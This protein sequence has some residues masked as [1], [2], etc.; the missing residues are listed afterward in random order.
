[1][2]NLDFKKPIFIEAVAIIITFLFTPWVSTPL[3]NYSLT[4]FG[5]I[6]FLADA[7]L[8]GSSILIVLF[9]ISIPIISIY[10]IY[11]AYNT[12]NAH[13]Y[14][15]ILFASVILIAIP[16]LA[17]SLLKSGAGSYDL[18]IFESIFRLQPGF[19]YTITAAGILFATSLAGL[20]T[21]NNTN[22]SNDN[23]STRNE[24]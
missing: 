9:L 22:T 1:M 3:I 21:N 7:N 20:S 15:K 16:P 18:L 14:K 11:T 8:G 13:G 24:S 12:N 4:G 17:Y 5:I 10:V 19:Y 23:E 2:E 6:E